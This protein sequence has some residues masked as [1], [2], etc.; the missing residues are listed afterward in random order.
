MLWTESNKNLVL[1]AERG[2]CLDVPSWKA[3]ETGTV[4]LQI[5]IIILHDFGINDSYLHNTGYKTKR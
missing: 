1:A 4:Y 5:I 3:S 2:N